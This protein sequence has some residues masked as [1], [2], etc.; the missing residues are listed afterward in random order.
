MPWNSII[1]YC[2]KQSLT[3]LY[4]PP[5]H[6][7]THPLRTILFCTKKMSNCNF[8]VYIS[9]HFVQINNTGENLFFKNNYPS[10]HLS[11]FLSSPI[12]Y[13]IKE[14]HISNYCI[15]LLLLLY[16]NYKTGNDQCLTI[17]FNVNKLS[18]L[19]VLFPSISNYLTIFVYFLHYLIINLIFVYFFESL[20]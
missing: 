9:S 20:V 13:C 14:E 19:L 12:C 1:F 8:T 6:P 15:Y 7:S 5:I 17:Y 11:I 3:R 4:H 18:Y 10:I 2:C 16:A